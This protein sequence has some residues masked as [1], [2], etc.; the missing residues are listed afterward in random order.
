MSRFASDSPRF[1]SPPRRPPVRCQFHLLDTSVWS[2]GWISDEAIKATAPDLPRITHCLVQTEHT[3][4]Y[5]LAILDSLDIEHLRPMTPRDELAQLS[6]FQPLGKARFMF[7]N[8][9]AHA[10]IPADSQAKFLSWSGHDFEDMSA[11]VMAG[12][13]IP[14]FFCN[15]PESECPR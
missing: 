15:R 13:R 12:R 6:T 10:R 7:L 4:W 14:K 1:A 11:D 9:D 5:H 2:F 3:P 8:L